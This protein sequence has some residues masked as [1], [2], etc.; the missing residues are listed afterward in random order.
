VRTVPGPTDRIV[1]VGAGLGGL[2]AA[3]RLAGAGRAVTVLEQREGPGGV[4]GQL[5]IDGY[6]FDTG[7]TVLTLPEVIADTLGSVGEELDDW[8]D[9]VPLDPIYRAFYPGGE[10][11]DI[12]A[13]PEATEAGIEAFAGPDEAAGYRRFVEWLR[14]LHRTQM[15]HFVDRNIDSP[16]GLV[17]PELA[18]LAALGGFG[19][20]EPAV[21]RFLRDPRVRRA[22][23]FQS[24]YVGL[25]PHEALALYAMIAYLDTVAGVVFPR[26]GIHTVPQA[27]AGAAAKH[28]VTFRYGTMVESVETAA[29][30]A[31]A[32]RTTD[33]ERIPAD[34]VVLAADLPHVFRDLLNRRPPT[35]RTAPSCVLVH[36]GSSARYSK[37]AH[38]NIHFGR[39]WRR[40]FRELTRTGELMSDPSLLVTNPTRTDPSLAPAGRQT[41]YVLA[42]APNT[43]A[44]IDWSVV[45]P[46]YADELLTTLH[47][48]GY[49]GFADAAEVVRVVTPADWQAAGLSAGTPFAA[50]HT[51]RQTGPFRP[52]NL[53][54]GLDNVV[55]AGAWTH[56]GVGVPMVL[57]SG[58]L[59]AERIT[60][61]R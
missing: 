12:R 9:L 59:A 24:L 61:P 50:A 51:M 41:Y 57:L 48:R 13:D 28:G 52:G 27:L 11:L 47:A 60:G 34:A 1:V 21:R 18:R 31:R 36:V 33:G 44:P 42:P 35:L 16:L 23:T 2:A 54:A 43:D 8:L 20:L 38:H 39:A 5:N 10:H 58:R 29:G 55:L 40:T 46:R 4:A 22:F 7:P 15:R 37:I 17:G 3:L 14:A 53:V 56:P 49:G 32:V 30:R 45:G 26:G 6:S 19:R 25:S